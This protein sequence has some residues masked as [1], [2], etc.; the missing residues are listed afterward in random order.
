MPR[1]KKTAKIIQLGITKT[2]VIMM[3]AMTTNTMII[4][5]GKI[6]QDRFMIFYKYK[7]ERVIN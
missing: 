4:M 6:L 1:I 7:M 5:N 3:K 2:I